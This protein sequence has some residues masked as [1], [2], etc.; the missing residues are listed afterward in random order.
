MT[1]K[2]FVSKNNILMPEPKGGL[3]F[4]NIYVDMFLKYDRELVGNQ[5][6]YRESDLIEYFEVDTT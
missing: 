2:D 3:S 1:I 5:W 6:S 4:S